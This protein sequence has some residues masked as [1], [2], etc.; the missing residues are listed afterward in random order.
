MTAWLNPKHPGSG[1]FPRKSNRTAS[2]ST[3]NLWINIHSLKL[4]LYHPGCGDFV[5]TDYFE[6]LDILPPLDD[7]FDPGETGDDN[8]K[9]NKGTC[10]YYVYATEDNEDPVLLKKFERANWV[11]L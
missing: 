8:I 7:N 9:N 1:G 3:E 4:K 2:K 5:F 10:Q 11:G 6:F